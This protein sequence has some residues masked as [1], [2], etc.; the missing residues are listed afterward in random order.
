MDLSG[1]YELLERFH[2]SNQ[3]PAF[4][5]GFVAAL[6]GAYFV[7]RLLR[8]RIT[9]IAAR[10][11]EISVLEK[12]VDKLTA[13]NEQLRNDLRHTEKHSEVIKTRA[14]ELAGSLKAQ[15]GI[16]TD[17]SA[18]CE[19]L[20]ERLLKEDHERRRSI[21]ANRESRRLV[22]SLNKQ[23]EAIAD[24]DGKIWQVAVGAGAP[25]FR[26]LSQRRTPILSLVNLKGGVGKTT[27]T[28][29]LAVAM[30]QHGWRVL[31][32]DLDYQG[33]LSQVLLSGK[34][35]N[36]L[37]VSRNLVDEAFKNPQEGLASFRKAI[38]RVTVAPDSQISIVASDDRLGDL[39]TAICHRWQSMQTA[40]D[41]RYRLR[42]II[43]S[44]EIADRFEFILLD[45]PPR[46]TTACINALTAS[47]YVIVPVLPD[48]VSTEA[49]P[50]LMKWLTNLRSLA[51]PELSVMGVIGNK[52]KFFKDLPV[53]RQRA[54]LES[55]A[56]PCADA[57]G[58][59][60]R[61]FPPLR[62]HD[63]LEHRLP[64]LDSKLQ[65]PYL[66]LAKQLNEVLPHYARSRSSELS[67]V[68]VNSA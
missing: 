57:L 52:V 11:R 30:S 65:L 54:E 6:L 50:R 56:G 35:L 21:E 48:P 3:L 68:T 33:S 13:E 19:R 12:H 7:L 29:N 9:S 44:S 17:L 18:E 38:Q 27:I 66:Q 61:F 47:D 14:S 36:E 59:P 42:S 37:F 39:E 28:A 46:L 25:P 22:E 64:A 32:V 23:L 43:H 2:Q 63:A 34:E 58:E 4:L 15:T 26:P 31:V 41:V 51:C 16:S 55:L 62:I 40:D 49:A 45:C 24:S 60:V 1:L 5:I 67:S 8:L 20:K 53:K 10:D